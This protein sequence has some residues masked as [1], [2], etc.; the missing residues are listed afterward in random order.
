[1]VVDNGFDYVQNRRDNYGFKL[2]LG[3]IMVDNRGF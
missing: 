3:S 2:K 1:M